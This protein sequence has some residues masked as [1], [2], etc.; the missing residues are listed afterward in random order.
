MRRLKGGEKLK[1]NKAHAAL[2]TKQSEAKWIGNFNMFNLRAFQ[3]SNKVLLQITVTRK[4][5][6]VRSKKK[7]LMIPLIIPQVTANEEKGQIQH[8]AFLLNTVRV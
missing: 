4:N 2:A 1:P 5:V 8:Y 6:V 7:K 3:N